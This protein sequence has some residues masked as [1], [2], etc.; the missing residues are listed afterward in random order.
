MLECQSQDIFPGFFFLISPAV[1]QVCA[2]ARSLHVKNLECLLCDTAGLRTV[3]KSVIFHIG[4]QALHLQLQK[5]VHNVNLNIID[6][7]F[8][9]NLDLG[10]L[11]SQY[12]NSVYCLF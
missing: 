2:V 6:S 1:K 10:P 12:F 7:L 9:N 11:L 5:L 4:S 3:S 8:F